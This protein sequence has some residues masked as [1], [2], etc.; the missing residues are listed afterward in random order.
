MYFTLN[1]EQDK[2]FWKESLC[3]SCFGVFL[4]QATVHEEQKGYGVRDVAKP[5]RALMDI[6][7]WSDR[8]G[9]RESGHRLQ[10]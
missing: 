4:S 8:G 2:P 10:Y 9:V 1:R 3:M 5:G 6:K 7:H